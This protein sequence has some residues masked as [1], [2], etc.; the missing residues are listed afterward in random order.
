MC[1]AS[2]FDYD[3]L[4]SLLDLY[5]FSVLILTWISIVVVYV[6]FPIL[7]NTQSTCFAVSVD[8]HANRNGGGFDG[9]HGGGHSE[10]AM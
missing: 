9:C 8:S 5:H 6:L 7:Q 3:A 10:N 4:F 1:V 2:N